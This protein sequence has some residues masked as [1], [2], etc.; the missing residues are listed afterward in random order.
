MTITIKRKNG[1]ACFSITDTGIGIP[2]A[3]QKFIFDRFFRA[4]NAETKYPNGM[5]L[6]LYIAKNIVEKHGGTMGFKS[7]EGKGSTFWFELPITNAQPT[8]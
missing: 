6:G 2:E 5:G 8:K 1:R 7:E 4:S 3:E